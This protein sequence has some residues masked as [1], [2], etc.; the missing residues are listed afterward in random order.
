MCVCTGHCLVRTE[1]ALLHMILLWCVGFL[2]YK[3]HDYYMR[4]N[5]TYARYS[6]LAM[7]MHIV[8]AAGITYVLSPLLNKLFT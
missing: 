8:L 2:L 1:M 6:L 5:R 3:T 4:T 7:Q